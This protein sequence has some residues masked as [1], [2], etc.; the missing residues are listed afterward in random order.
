[1]SGT[2]YKIYSKSF[3]ILFSG[4]MRKLL[5]KTTFKKIWKLLDPVI[6]PMI[7]WAKTISYCFPVMTKYHNLGNL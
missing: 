3:K 5:P 2:V 4:G 7:M 6:N 1:M